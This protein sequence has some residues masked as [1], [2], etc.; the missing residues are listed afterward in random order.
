M[1]KR[2]LSLLVAVLMLLS[3][4]AAFALPAAAKTLYG[5]V[6]HDGAVNKKDSLA[7]RK[8][9]ADNK[10]DIDKEAADVYYDGTVNKKDSLRLK[11]YLAGWKVTLGPEEAEESLKSGDVFLF[12][13]YEQDNDLSNGAEP[14]E[15][16]V[17][18]V[19]DGY[20]KLLSKYAL[21]C[22]PYNQ[23]DTAMLW[24]NCSLRTWLN[25][26]FCST[27]FSASENAKIAITD[28]LNRENPE[29]RLIGGSITTDKVYLAEAYDLNC[30]DYGFRGDYYCDDDA[31]QCR[32]T[33]YAIA[34]GCWTS[35]DYRYYDSCYWWVRTPGSSYRCAMCVKPGGYVDMAGDNVAVTDVG[36]RPMIRVKLDAGDKPQPRAEVHKG[37]VMTFGAYEQSGSLSDGREPIEWIVL[38]VRNGKA[39]LLSKYALDA[40]PYNEDRATYEWER[41]SLRSWLNH[42]FFDTAFSEA[43]KRTISAVTHE[44][45]DNPKYG[46]DGGDFTTDAVY[47]PGVDEI[48][49]RTYGFDPDP[50][51][52]DPMRRCQASAALKIKQGYARDAEYDCIYWLRT[53]GY[54]AERVATVYDGRVDLYGEY[55]DLADC[56]VGV[57]PAMWIRI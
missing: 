32:P 50:N 33:P 36:V 28:N 10:Y 3:A 19:Y 49:D 46:T 57:R 31:R 23:T 34:Q 42:E 13:A 47:L 40:L 24:E 1:T 41:C 38:E 17:L 4:F 56:A 25:N 8:Y 9:L 53:P 54:D 14:I 52:A 45:V 51:A 18:S 6:Y 39:L 15:W 21:E 11:Q 29:Y 37:D 16:I 35:T 2:T 12:G 22:M 26:D 5:D 43:E 44:N 7:L 30:V 27:A 48:T 55:S 20:A